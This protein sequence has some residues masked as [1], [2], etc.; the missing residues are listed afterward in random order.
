ML[1]YLDIFQWSRSVSNALSMCFNMA[2]WLLPRDYSIF[3][4]WPY[5]NIFNISSMLV[6]RTFR[7]YQRTEVVTA[8]L[9]AAHTPSKMFIYGVSTLQRSGLLSK[10][11]ST[12]SR[13][14]LWL[15]TLFHSHPLILTIVEY[16]SKSEIRVKGIE[17]NLP[18][19]VLLMP[20]SV[21]HLTMYS[22]MATIP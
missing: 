20:V 11:L 18:V 22:T 21:R 9:S 15:A 12:R 5:R 10:L 14:W 2:S 1:S 3:S 16:T 17:P 19:Q 8:N 13:H 6:Q 7:P 4:N